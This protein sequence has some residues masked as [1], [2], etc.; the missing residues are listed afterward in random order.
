MVIQPSVVHDRPLPFW[1]K[2]YELPGARWGMAPERLSLDVGG[3]RL[4]ASAMRFAKRVVIVPRDCRFVLT[5][6]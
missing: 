6:R 5:V 2:G 1:L 3:R 4:R